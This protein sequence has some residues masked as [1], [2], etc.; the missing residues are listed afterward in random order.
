MNKCSE[1]SNN[2]QHFQ[3]Q[4]TEL[5][6]KDLCITAKAKHLEIVYKNT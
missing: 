4:V 1:V 2:A 5:V 6:S 3:Y